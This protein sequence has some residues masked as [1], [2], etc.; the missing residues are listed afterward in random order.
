MRWFYQILAVVALTV[1]CGCRSVVNENS[2][3][4]SD[5]IANVF[6]PICTVMTAPLSGDFKKCTDCKD[7]KKGTSSDV[8]FF[9]FYYPIVSAGNESIKSAMANGDIKELYYADYSVRFFLIVGWY[10]I[11]AYGK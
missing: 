3:S 8:I 11:T 4:F 1:A 9:Q 7:L 6:G 2:V 5:P 10:T